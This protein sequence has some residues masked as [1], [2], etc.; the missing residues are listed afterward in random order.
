VFTE[1]PSGELAF[2]PAPPPTTEEVTELLTTVRK[3]I[4]RHLGKR[5]LLDD[6][7]GGVDPR[8]EQAPLLADCYATSIA[9]RQTLG[10]FQLGLY[11]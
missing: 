11:T 9:H 5:G 3:R 6:D 1:A 8:S 10:V 7:H 2:H 4:L